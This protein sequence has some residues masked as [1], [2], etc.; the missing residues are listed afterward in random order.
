LLL[1]S[2]WRCLLE[3]TLELEAET[4]SSR[5]SSAFAVGLKDENVGTPMARRSPVPGMLHVDAT[6]IGSV[7][8]ES[9]LMLLT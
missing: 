8:G 5:A 6:H 9:W 7:E 3:V 2:S 1:P 4:G